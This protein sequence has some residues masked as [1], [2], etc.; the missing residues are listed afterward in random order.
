MKSFQ[1]ELM[2]KCLNLFELYLFIKSRLN[3]RLFIERSEIN[4]ETFCRIISEI[5][6]LLSSGIKIPLIY[7]HLYLR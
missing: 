2:K 4:D 6:K 1:N 5:I 7:F 3:G